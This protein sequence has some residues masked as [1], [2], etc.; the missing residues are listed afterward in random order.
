[1]LKPTHLILSLALAS[2]AA[3]AAADNTPQIHGAFRGRWQELTNSAEQRFQV[4]NARL[5]LQGNLSKPI[6]Y[7][8]QLDLCDQGSMKILDAYG[9]LELA[10][11]LHVQAG[12]FRMPYGVEPFRGPGNYI[13]ANRAF[14]GKQMMIYRAVGAKVAYALPKTGLTLE[15]G[16]FNPATIGDHKAYYKT[17]SWS[18]KAIFKCTRELSLSGSFASVKPGA[19]RGNLADA[20][21]EWKDKSWHMASEYMYEHYVGG[22][23][24]NAHSWMAFASWHKPIALSVFNQWSVQGRLDG[25]TRH[26]SLE[27]GKED[28]PHSIRGTIGSTLSHIAGSTHADVRINYDHYFK[29][30]S[31]AQAPNLI[32]C[33]LVIRF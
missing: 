7:F 23:F 19:L 6:D 28:I 4:K 27:T 32:T 11:G 25:I 3:N 29:Y 31:P 9:R 26:Y 17:S 10:R 16:I 21:V 15:A 33:E 14:M 5:S 20:S 2:V 24:A 12:Q 1:M 8:L 13:F 18:T 30:D 22:R